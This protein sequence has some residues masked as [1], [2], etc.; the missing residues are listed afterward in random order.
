MSSFTDQEVAALDA[1]HD[2]RRRS[3]CVCRDE[4]RHVLG[5]IG[6]QYAFRVRVSHRIIS[7]GQKTEALLVLVRCAPD[8]PPRLLLCVGLAKVSVALEGDHVPLGRRGQRVDGGFIVAE[9]RPT[10]FAH[11]VP[12]QPTN[13][14]LVGFDLPAQT[15][16]Q[17]RGLRGF[18]GF[19]R[20]EA[21]PS[22]PF[23][24]SGCRHYSCNAS[25]SAAASVAANTRRASCLIRTS[26]SSVRPGLWWKSHRLPISLAA[27][28]SEHARQSL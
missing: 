26:S 25:P 13:A 14:Q 3:R 17:F 18:G 20:R 1:L 27:A 2:R 22:L 7:N 11:A 9:R 5:A 12:E 24:G 15:L 28:N 23:Q 4:G 21:Q 8:C 16:E 10:V 19:V 6:D